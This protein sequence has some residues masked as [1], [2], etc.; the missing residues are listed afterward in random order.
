MSSSE[1]IKLPSIQAAFKLPGYI[2]S[3]P[4]SLKPRKRVSAGVLSISF[5]PLRC[6]LMPLIELECPCS[7]TAAS[8]G[9]YHAAGPRPAPSTPT[10]TKICTAAALLPRNWM[11]FKEYPHRS[12][13]Q[14]SV[15]GSTANS[16]NL[17]LSF[18]SRHSIP[19]PYVD[20]MGPRLHNASSNI[21]EILRMGRKELHN[22]AISYRSASL[23]LNLGYRFSNAAGWPTPLLSRCLQSYEVI[24]RKRAL[25]D[26]A[27]LVWVPHR[28]TVRDLPIWSLTVWE[29][30]L[31]EMTFHSQSVQVKWSTVFKPLVILQNEQGIETDCFRTKSPPKKNISRV[32][33]VHWPAKMLGT[34]P[35]AR[36]LFT[37]SRRRKNKKYIL[38]RESGVF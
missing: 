17:I 9:F 37:E 4:A 25:S 26:A 8:M 32:I 31:A 10:G 15:T 28:G 27:N 13:K 35:L 14:D 21:I 19:Y 36:P 38:L 5:P 24:W 6:S 2:L 16:P 1:N 12:H 33:K 3:S 22:C 11:Q 30:R 29:T 23:L 7:N 20:F 18:Q 34:H